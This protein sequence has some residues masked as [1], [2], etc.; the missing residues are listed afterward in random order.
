MSLTSLKSPL[1]C[2]HNTGRQAGR[3]VSYTL[4]HA[5]NVVINM[6][7]TCTTT[8]HLAVGP[9]LSWDLGGPTVYKQGMRWTAVHKMLGPAV[10][11]PKPSNCY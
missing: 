2:R 1:G 5:K 10:G 6:L 8:N 7:T 9:R 11:Q 4:C 3:T